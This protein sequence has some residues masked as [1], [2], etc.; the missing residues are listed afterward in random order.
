VVIPVVIGEL[1]ANRRAVAPSRGKID[2]TAGH[3]VIPAGSGILVA[4]PVAGL[5]LRPF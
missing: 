4:A 5:G 3:T 2:S 1:S